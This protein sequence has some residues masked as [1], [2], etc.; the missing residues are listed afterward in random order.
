MMPR[1]LNILVADDMS[2]NRRLLVRHLTAMPP[3]SELGWIITE[4]RTGEEALD[5]IVNKGEKFDMIFMDE[6]FDTA[7]GALR[8]SDVI[9]KLREYHQQTEVARRQSRCIMIACSGNC[10]AEDIEWYTSKGA[11][12]TLG[13]PLPF[14]F[15]LARQL[16]DVLEVTKVNGGYGGDSNGSISGIKRSAETAGLS[17]AGGMEAQLEKIEAMKVKQLRE[18][19]QRCGLSTNGLKAELV[20][21]LTNVVVGQKEPDEVDEERKGSGEHEVKHP[22][23][24][25]A[26]SRPG[27]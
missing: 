13:K 27:H 2:F 24:R 19:L 17:A 3:F 5:L 11:D 18:A 21:R 25:R 16:I 20:R 8:G 22:G 26:T 15:E 12:L 9:E 10:L 14:R 23:K 1:E 7:G 6:H 4:C